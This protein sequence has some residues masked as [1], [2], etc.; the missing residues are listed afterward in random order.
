MPLKKKTGRP[1]KPHDFLRI[2]LRKPLLAVLRREA[3]K[4]GSTVTELVEIAVEK[5]YHAK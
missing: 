5:T 1:R 4:R 2:R 3:R